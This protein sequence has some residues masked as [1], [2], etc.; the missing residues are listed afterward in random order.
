MGISSG[1]IGHLIRIDGGQIRKWPVVEFSL[2]PNPAEPRTLGVS[3]IKAL[4]SDA[5]LAVPQAFNEV[6]EDER[7]TE[8][9]GETDLSERAQVK[10]RIFLVGG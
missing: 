8:E 4:F 10:A 5:G 9:S 2:T 3:Q 7:G 6:R 1:S